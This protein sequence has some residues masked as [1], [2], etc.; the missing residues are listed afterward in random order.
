MKFDIDS[1]VRQG[2]FAV[3]ILVAVFAVQA[4]CQRNKLPDVKRTPIGLN[5]LG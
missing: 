4:S 1:L 5:A 3:M 2:R